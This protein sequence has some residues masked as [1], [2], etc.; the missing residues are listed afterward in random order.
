MF[1]NAINPFRLPMTAIQDFLNSARIFLLVGLCPVSPVFAADLTAY[2]EEWPPY[3]YVIDHEVKGISTEILRVA[4][5]LAKLHCEF[6]LVPWARAYKIVSNTPNTLIYSTARDPTR[7]KQFVWVG[8]IL[9]RNAWAYGKTG[10]NT[11]IHGFK[12]L[13]STRIGVVRD[14]AAQNDLIAVGVP[15]SSFLVVNSHLDALRLMMLDKINLVVTTEIGMAWN[16][17]IAGISPAA[18]TKVIKVKEGDLYYAF[19]LK[20]DPVVVVKL[21]ASIDKLRREGK[22]DSIVSQYIKQKN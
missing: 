2:T 6:R 16:M 11:D 1:V 14:D 18:I 9:P 7:E 20:S 3:N 13:T 19:N 22:I 10:M 15:I 17:Q 4:C 12:D 21:Q 5:E 8:P